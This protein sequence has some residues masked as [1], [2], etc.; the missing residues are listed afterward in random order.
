M[1]ILVIGIIAAIVAPKLDNLSPKYLLRASARQIASNI[2]NC[3]SQSVVTG[4]TYSLVYDLDNQQYWILLPQELD[5]YG[6]PATD[7]RE[8]VLPKR[9]PTKGVKIVEIITADDESHTSGQIQLDLSPF[10]NTGSHIVVVQYRDQE[11]MRI[12]VR[13]NALLGFS[14]FHYEETGFVKY[15]PEEDDESYGQEPEQ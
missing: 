12:W 9:I 14:T 10:G 3:S 6:E 1:V 15:E 4:K 8:P 5:E 2:E 13:T 11:D 7:E